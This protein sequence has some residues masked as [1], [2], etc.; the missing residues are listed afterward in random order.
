[1]VSDEKIGDWS[2]PAFYTMSLA[3]LGLQAGASSAEVL[4]DGL[5]AALKKAAM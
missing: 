3:S 5:R 1:M 2:G 4:A